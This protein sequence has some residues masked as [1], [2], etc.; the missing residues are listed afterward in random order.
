M[1]P[2][3]SPELFVYL[4]IEGVKRYLAL[5]ED[6]KLNGKV[7]WHRQ[8]EGMPVDVT[9]HKRGASRKYRYIYL[10]PRNVLWEVKLSKEDE[11]EF[12]IWAA[13]LIPSDYHSSRTLNPTSFSECEIDLQT[14]MESTYA[15]GDVIEE[16]LKEEKGP[17]FLDYIKG[18]FGLEPEEK[19]K[20]VRRRKHEQLL[21]LSKE[22]L[23]TLLRGEL[24]G[25]IRAAEF[26]EVS[27]R[28][29]HKL[30]KDGR[31][32]INVEGRYV[33]SLSELEI[34]KNSPRPHGV[35][36]KKK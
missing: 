8:L 23:V 10:H 21:D 13:V 18:A 7:V 4:D 22:Q 14:W 17:S 16:M 25:T 5:E 24:V 3:I 36:I 1:R 34:F 6:L 29:V 19:S 33:F 20:K 27:V 31:I 30:A 26:L 12:G 9:A 32:G 35:N 15:I 2:K 28:R 11:E